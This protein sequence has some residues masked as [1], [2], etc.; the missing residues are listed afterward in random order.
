M[1]ENVE[2]TEFFL[3]KSNKP[4]KQ[5][6]LKVAVESNSYFLKNCQRQITIDQNRWKILKEIMRCP[7]PEAATG[8]VHFKKNLANFTENTSVGVSF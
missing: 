1:F 5:I 4:Q 8:G 2:L 6:K 7:F 3:Q